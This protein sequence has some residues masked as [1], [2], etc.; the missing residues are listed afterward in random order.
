MGSQHSKPSSSRHSIRSTSTAGSRSSGRTLKRLSRH[1]NTLGYHYHN[2]HNSHPNVN[3]NINNSSGRL[4]AEDYISTSNINNSD[5]SNSNSNSNNSDNSNSNSNSNSNNGNTTI[6][7]P[8]SLLSPPSQQEQQDL[9]QEKQE[10]PASLGQHL[11]PKRRSNEYHRGNSAMLNRRSTSPWSKQRSKRPISLASS[12]DDS[13][14]VCL[15]SG[16]FSQIDHPATCSTITTATDFSSA[17]RQS[18]FHQDKTITLIPPLQ[19]HPKRQPIQQAALKTQEILDR[20]SEHQN[21]ASVVLNEAAAATRTPDDRCEFYKATQ[22]WSQQTQ[23]PAAMVW[24]ARCLLDGWGIPSNRSLGLDQLKRLAEMGCWEAY[25]PLADYYREEIKTSR[26]LE[27]DALRWYKAA[28]ELN[29]PNEPII[30][31]AQYRLGE[32]CAQGQGV[33]ENHPEALSWFEKSANN[34]NK[35]GQY[36]SGVYYEKGIGVDKNIEKAK[37]YFL[38]SAKQDFADA[39]SALGILLIDQQQ[40]YEQG[41]EWLDRSAQMD[42]ARGLLKLGIMYENGQGV[43]CNPEQA[44]SYYK[45]AAITADDPKAQYLVGLNYRLGAMGLPKDVKE[46]GRYLARSARGGFAPAQR[47]IGLMLAQGLMG[48]KDE[49]SAFHWFQAAANQGDAHAL[50]LLGSCYETGTA[51]Q[52]NYA[53]AMSYY[54]KAVRSPSPFQSAAQ[55][56]LAQLLIKMGRLRDAYEW[57]VRAAS[58]TTN[59]L[60]GDTAAAVAG[61]KA[62]LMVARYH[63]HGWEGV[64]KDPATAFN[65]LKTLI[66]QAPNEPGPLYWLAA[67]Y[68]EGIPDV[69]PPNPV[70]AFDYYMR[71]AETN[72]T[73]AQFQVAFMLSNGQGIERDR[74]AAFKWYKKAAQKGHT[75]ACHSL[76]LYYAKG[77]G[78]VRINYRLA[79]IYFE[80]AAKK[81]FVPAM[82]SL[83]TLYRMM[84]SSA[85]QEQPSSSSSEN[86]QNAV[87]VFCQQMEAQQRKREMMIHWY[88]KAATKGDAGAQRELGMLY[89]SGLGVAQNYEQAFILFERAAAQKDPRATLML[90]SYYQNGLGGV[91]PKAQRALELY[92]QAVQL[93]A[94]TAYYAAARVY[95]YQGQYEE[96]FMQ[97]KLAA[98]DN[99][100]AEMSAGKYSKLMVARYTLGYY[101]DPSSNSP[102]VIQQLDGITKEMAFQSLHLLATHDEFPPCYYWLAN[103]YYQGNGTDINMEKALEY[104]LE[105]ANKTDNV[106]AMVRVAQMFE[107]GQGM[108]EPNPIE[109]FKYY[110]SSAEEQH[111][112]GEYNMGMAY[113]RGLYAM[114]INLGEAVVWFTRSATK[115]PASSWALG[116][117]ALENGDQ[118]VAIAWWQKSIR[119]GHVP[120]MRSLAKLL[121]RTSESEEDSPITQQEN[122]AAAALSGQ[123]VVLS[124]EAGEPHTSVDQA[125]SLLEEAVRSGDPESLVML[126]KI[127]QKNATLQ[128][129]QP[130]QQQTQNYGDDTVDAM[131]IEEDAEILFQKRQAQQ[132]LAIRCFEQAADMGHV[133]AMFLAAQSWH[134]Q[135]QFAAALGLYERAAQHNHDLSR[136]MRARYKIAGLGGIE[137]NPKAGYQELLACAQ[138][139]NCVDAYNSLGQCHELGLGTEQDDRCALEWYLRSAEKTQDA[140]AMF[141]IGQMHAQGRVPSQQQHHHQQN[142]DDTTM[143]E[144]NKD[145]EALQWYRFACDS[146][147]HPRAHYYIGLYHVHGIRSE[148]DN[149]T[150]LLQPDIPTAIEHFRKAAE[151]DDRDAMVQVAQLLLF[152]ITTPPAGADE[153]YYSN[154]NNDN[155]KNN[156]QLTIS[157]H[158]I[159]TTTILEGLEWLERAAQLGSA[160]AQCELGK[161]YHTGKPGVLDQ[162]FERAYDYFC[163]AASQKDKTATLFIGTYH[164]HGIHVP[165]NL[166]L[167]CEWYQLAVDTHPGWWLAELALARLLHSSKGACPEAYQLFKSAHQHALHHYQ[168][169]SA[170]MMCALYELYGWAN[171]P[172]RPAEAASTLLHLAERPHYDDPKTF[173][174]VAHCYA[175]GLGL[176]RDAIK[177]FEWYG[178]VVSLYDQDE[179][180]VEEDTET[181]V[182]EALYRLAEFYQHGWDNVVPVDQAKAEDLFNLAAQHGFS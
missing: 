38:S 63:L 46:A 16:V 21:Q 19:L 150:F 113:W 127:H 109:A 110:K 28:A 168:E 179:D 55:L 134:S 87:R 50:C 112:E 129:Q 37:E 131:I 27:K 84:T 119:Q 89:D 49:K 7:T 53:K 105:A 103:C 137:A 73:D 17:S 90:G 82:A 97:Y 69:C 61:R 91:E 172:A 126:G 54:Q 59:D 57:F 25:Y 23:D 8:P 116:Q 101:Y 22:T 156:D 151:Q 104:Y 128:D 174:H 9:V 99:G 159:T 142:D 154:N 44:M 4:V 58:H 40:L 74:P 47:I 125:I 160:E 182:G 162:D 147:N 170:T 124:N 31:F 132:D 93:G 13:V 141:R 123:Q 20:L 171:I 100:L 181:Y 157:N 36:I 163:R 146:R 71:A 29:M 43:P 79:E 143:E 115:H 70:Q 92:Q 11:Y 107:Q 155:N 120:S 165:P 175:Q 133:E 178:R 6:T 138:N 114:P 153:S 122:A 144:Q 14:S 15:S 30:G 41:K 164:E 1:F 78:G 83:A 39:Q 167:A 32:M 95:Q 145:M 34:G 149:T 67:C 117:M 66:D 3:N 62:M 65:M 161:L 136:V 148:H 85:P 108:E 42:N 135:Q 26:R 130:Q 88:R 152:T 177:A 2:H 166:D 5:N 75:V 33:M 18:L 56:V 94:S 51:V 111:P 72:D 45:T 173:L 180:T 76:G 35:Y 118:D 139:D 176:N 86:N 121:L 140:E 24:V 98:Q 64:T 10:Q 106:D 60:V 80:T 158:I 12:S 68:E 81:G 169:T 96:A 77:A 52:M 48:R 102:V